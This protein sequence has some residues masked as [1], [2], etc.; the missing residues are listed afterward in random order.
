[1]CPL[2]VGLTSPWTRLVA[3]RPS[4][5]TM[6][7]QV[8][9]KHGHSTGQVSGCCDPNTRAA[10]LQ[11]FASAKQKSASASVQQFVCCILCW[12]VLGSGGRRPCLGGKH[13]QTCAKWYALCAHG[14]PLA[15]VLCGA[16]VLLS[17][18]LHGTLR[19][20]MSKGVRLVSACCGRWHASR[21]LGAP[22]TSLHVG[23]GQVG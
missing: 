15:D 14:D 11:S 13:A 4:S 1:M 9:R 3:G 17:C 20:H 5:L 23:W 2:R 6:G 8:G 21:A 7:D 10:V 19:E 22:S 18:G 12:V 16:P